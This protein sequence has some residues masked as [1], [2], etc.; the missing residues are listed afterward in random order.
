MYHGTSEPLQ[1]GSKSSLGDRSMGDS[2]HEKRPLC[3]A[4]ISFSKLGKPILEIPKIV[5]IILVHWESTI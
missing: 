5:L 1:A 4:L 2:E 3:S